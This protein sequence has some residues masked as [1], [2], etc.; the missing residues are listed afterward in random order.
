M[1]IQ[2]SDSYE[3]IDNLKMTAFE[4]ANLLGESFVENCKQIETD[5]EVM[6][7]SYY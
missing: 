7:Q 2:K 1:D 6:I 3:D 5:I 4:I